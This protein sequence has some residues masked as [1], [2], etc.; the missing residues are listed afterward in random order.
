MGFRRSML[1]H[2]IVHAFVEIGDEYWISNWPSLICGQGDVRIRRCHHSRM[3]FSPADELNTLCTPATHNSVTEYLEESPGGIIQRGVVR[4]SNTLTECTNG[5][6][7]SNG[8]HQNSAWEHMSTTGRVPYAH[9]AYTPDNYSF[10]LFG[11]TPDIVT[12]GGHSN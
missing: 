12:L 4:G 8:P 6:I 10:R 2:E 7:V 5:D 11:D 9:P 1:T 3:S